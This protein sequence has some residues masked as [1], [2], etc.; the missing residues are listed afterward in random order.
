VPAVSTVNVT[1]IMEQNMELKEEVAAVL[2][3]NAQ[4]Q[5][6]LANLQNSGFPLPVVPHQ[7]LIETVQTR[8]MT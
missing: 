5:E 8:M 3:E 7:R 4:L 6:R 1:R 2:Q